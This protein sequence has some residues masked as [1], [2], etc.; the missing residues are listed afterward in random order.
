MDP[1]GG[2]INQYHQPSR[3]PPSP[4]PPAI[5]SPYLTTPFHSPNPPGLTNNHPSSSWPSSPLIKP[6]SVGSNHADP[7]PSDVIW[8]H[9]SSDTP[10]SLPPPPPQS[11]YHQPTGLYPSIS[12]SVL[13]YSQKPSSSREPR[14]PIRED[15]RRPSVMDDHLQAPVTHSPNDPAP[16]TANASKPKERHTRIRVSGVERN[17]RDL[18]V[19]FDAWVRSL[20]QLLQ[21]SAR[22]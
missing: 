16:R 17:R 20:L 18:Y 12:P 21:V 14:S 8:P 15:G 11:L 6:H 7:D 3:L 19:K 13:T 4:H 22:D 5:V 2:S 10:Q 1:L 9:R